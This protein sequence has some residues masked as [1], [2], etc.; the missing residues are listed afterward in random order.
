MR[1]LVSEATICRLV[2]KM[3][4]IYSL[5]HRLVALLWYNASGFGVKNS[6]NL[7]NVCQADF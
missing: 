7:A 1:S 4:R 3:F 5:G 2:H 6:I